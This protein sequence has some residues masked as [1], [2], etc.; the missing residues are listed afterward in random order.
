MSY[1]VCRLLLLLPSFTLLS[2]NANAQMSAQTSAQTPAREVAPEVAERILTTLNEARPD[3]EYREVETTPIEGLY[4]VRMVHGPLLYV[5]ASGEYFVAGEMFQALPGQFVNLA[6]LSFTKERARLIAA[7]P[8]EDMIIF[9]PE[10]PRAVVTVFTDVDCGYCR[11]LHSEMQQYHDLGIAIR[12]LAF[13]RQGPVGPTAD[14]MVSAW[15]SADRRKSLTD[16]K[17]GKNIRNN[18]CSDHPVTQQFELGAEVGIRGTPA[19]IL[20]DGSLVSGYRPAKE[21]AEILGLE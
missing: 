16:L 10:N 20:A 6:E 15:C 7:V 21:L 17:N 12:Y 2:L 5:D 3:F 19:I 8:E 9:A 14:K 13:P 18:Q 4:Q 1:A 11:Q